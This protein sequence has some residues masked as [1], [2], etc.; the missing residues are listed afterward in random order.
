[1]IRT[2]WGKFSQKHNSKYMAK[3]WFLLAME[4]LHVSVYSG[5]IQVLTTF[6]LKEFYIIC[7]NRVVML[8]SH[9][10]F[11]CFCWAKF[12]AMSIVL[13]FLIEFTS[14]YGLNTLQGWHTSELFDQNI[15]RPAILDR[16][17]EW[18]HITT[19]LTDSI[20]ICHA[21]T[22]WA[23][24]DHKFLTFKITPLTILMYLEEI[25]GAEREN[26]SK[27][28][29]SSLWMIKAF[30]GKQFGWSCGLKGEIMLH[31]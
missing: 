31:R 4:K 15:E 23:G 9:N 1:L 27:Q 6:S 10:H 11:A 13:V 20:T 5:H 2:R 3:W 28:W 7:L 24:L 14:T 16:N 17:F 8:R 19:I 18:L 26:H 22:V 21:H 29:F 25:L 30:W 12:G